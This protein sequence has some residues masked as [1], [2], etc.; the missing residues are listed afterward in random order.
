MELPDN[1]E[2]IVLTPKSTVETIRAGYV[3]EI[4][5]SAS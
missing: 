3:P 4:H 5:T 2:V 1:S